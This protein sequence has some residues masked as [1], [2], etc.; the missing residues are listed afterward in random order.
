MHEIPLYSF[1]PIHTHTSS[2]SAIFLKYT[3]GTFLI[4][5]VSWESHVK[6]ICFYLR[7]TKAGGER[8]PSHPSGVLPFPGQHFFPQ[9]FGPETCDSLHSLS[10]SLLDTSGLAIWRKKEE[11]EGGMGDRRV[12][13][14]STKTQP[15]PEAQA[16]HCQ[17][18]LTSSNMKRWV[19]RR[20]TGTSF[21]CGVAGS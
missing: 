7:Q 3:I 6:N 11:G 16:A 5:V 9:R 14:I 4:T 10:P 1:I 12:S 8:G 15:T 18:E 20:L 21:S 13:L 17:E 2:L 19:R